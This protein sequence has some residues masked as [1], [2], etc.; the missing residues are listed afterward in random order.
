MANPLEKLSPLFAKLKGLAPRLN[1]QQSMQAQIDLKIFAPVFGGAMVILGLVVLLIPPYSPPKQRGVEVPK[2]ASSRVTITDEKTGKSAPNAPITQR[3]L[4]EAEERA[5]AENDQPTHDSLLAAPVEAME[6]G[7]QSQRLPKIADDG[8]RPWFVYS[9]PFN[10]I[11]PRPRIAVVFADLGL[12]R[13]TT[14]SAINSLPGAVT[15]IFSADGT[16]EAWMNR[17]RSSGHEVILSVP[18]EPF[19]Y[20]AN[21]PG[22][23]TLLSNSMLDENLR[24]LHEA[25]AMGKGYVGLTT[26]T[27]SRFTSSPDQLK[28]IME[29]VYSRGLLWLDARLVP[30]SSASAVSAAMKVPSVQSDFRITTDKSQAAADLMFRDAETSARHSGAATVLVY[31]SPMS[32]QAVKGWVKSFPE[33]GFALAPVS[34]MVQ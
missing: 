34:A 9:R 27:G 7:P 20:P 6:E 25:M 28:P 26:L 10:R 31:A 18:M 29:E 15:L 8:R 33:K 3:Q 22:P 16:S 1:L 32:V 14:D 17:A 13:L 11:D 30:L 19:D 2:W 23:R 21:D 5:I 4:T 24:R 12:N